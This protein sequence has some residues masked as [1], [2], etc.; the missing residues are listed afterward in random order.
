MSNWKRSR[1][2]QVL[3]TILALGFSTRLIYLGKRQPWTDELMQALIVR[4]DSPG[5]MLKHLRAGMYLPAPL[6]YLAQKIFVL[7]FGTSPWVL[8][9]HAAIF[10]TLSIWVF[11]RIAQRIFGDR[12]ALY[13]TF[14]FAFFPLQFHFSRE[15]RPWSLLLLLS[16]VVCE[17]LLASVG[18]KKW[19]VREWLNLTFGMT[20]VLYTGW[21]GIAALAAVGTALTMLAGREGREPKPVE[22]GSGLSAGAA[23]WP[24]VTW[25]DLLTCWTAVAAAVVLFVPWVRYTWMR[26]SITSIGELF[27]PKLVLRLVKETGD[28][29]YFVS[30]ILLLGVVTGVRAMR[31]HGR[32]TT[33]SFLAAWAIVPL[34]VVLIIDAAAGYFFGIEQIL[35]SVPAMALLAGYGLS[36]V[37]EQMTILDRLPYATSSPAMVYAAILLGAT[38]VG[39]WSHALNE[40]RDWLGTARYL[41]ATVREGDAVTMPETGPLLEYYAPSLASYAVSDLNPGAGVLSHE[42]VAR[43]FVVCGRRLVHNRCAGFRAAAL[44][45]KAWRRVELSGFEIFVREK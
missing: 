15:G 23:A 10:G 6:D 1:T 35:F 33:L 37:G 25:S 19:R 7:A 44:K 38:G 43:R 14:L 41:Q 2:A 11:F 42:G 16:L 31:R 40:P 29:S 34:P 20:I 26:P 18:R 21:H 13:S 45:D 12:I 22:D 3:G 9:F 17:Q 8:R 5:E 24:R 39:A 36:Y 4:H 27:H 32:G 28:G 30:M